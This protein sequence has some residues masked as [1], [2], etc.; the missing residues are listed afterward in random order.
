MPEPPRFATSADAYQYAC[1]MDAP[2]DAR[3]ALIAETVRVASPHYAQSVDRLV[4]RLTRSGAGLTSPGPGDWMPRFLLPDEAGRLTSLDELLATG[5]LVVAFHRG[6]WCPFCRM[7]MV[8]LAEAQATAAATRIVA[9]TPEQRVYN[10]R[11]KQETGA[12]FRI[13]SDADNAYALSLDLAF[14]VGDELRAILTG[15]GVDAPASHGND[16]WML[17]IP[18]TFVVRQDGVVAARF[19]DPDFRRRANMDALSE[20][21]RRAV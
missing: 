2:L 20:A 3:L 7:N 11:L 5:P 8:A 19:M 13:L 17:P 16:F 18:A 6:R 9:I 12:A 4:E 10:A 1:A 15:L 14:W 21:L